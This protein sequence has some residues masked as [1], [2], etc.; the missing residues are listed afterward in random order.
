MTPQ[1]NYYLNETRR[2]FLKHTGAG[3]GA[4]GLA[5]ALDGNLFAAPS[6]DPLSPRRP[7]RPAKALSLIHI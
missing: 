4:L 1:Q 2:E 5:S 6:A 3:L 7:H